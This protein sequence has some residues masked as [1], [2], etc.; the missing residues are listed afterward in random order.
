MSADELRPGRR[1]DVY[2]KQKKPAAPVPKQTSRELYEL[3]ALAREGIPPATSTAAKL[4]R[5]AEQGGDFAGARRLRDE[6][7]E[8]APDLERVARAKEKLERKAARRAGR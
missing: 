8:R 2:G 1:L 4:I 5:E 6:V 7:K 3:A